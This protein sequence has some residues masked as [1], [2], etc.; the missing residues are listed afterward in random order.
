MAPLPESKE[1]KKVQTKLYPFLVRQQQTS[2]SHHNGNVKNKDDKPKSTKH[3]Q[4]KTTRFKEISIS[5]QTFDSLDKF[6]EDYEE[7]DD[8]DD[9]DIPLSMLTV[10]PKARNSNLV[11]TDKQILLPSN[12][13]HEMMKKRKR[14]GVEKATIANKIILV[15][16][17]V[18]SDHLKR[19]NVGVPSPLGQADAVH[20]MSSYNTKF[21]NDD[22]GTVM[23]ADDGEWHGD[24]DAEN[25]GDHNVTARVSLSP[26]TKTSTLPKLD[27]RICSDSAMDFVMN[28]DSG[29]R[30]GN[31]I[32]KRLFDRSTHGC[33]LHKTA[34]FG[35]MANQIYSRKRTFSR[36]TSKGA[37]NECPDWILSSKWKIPSWVSL[38]QPIKYS[39]KNTSVDHMVWDDMGV[40]LAVAC[41]V[42]ISIYDW[43]MVR[44]ADLQGRRDRS[45]KCRDSGWKIEPI[46]QFRA[47]SPVSKLVWN[48]FHPDELVVCLR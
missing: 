42:T 26:H 1:T 41:D 19:G 44:A 2:S 14:S 30:R 48:H 35:G 34:G 8:D 4:R 40:L 46:L 32:L 39:S 11:R 38:A 24:R 21:S 28:G 5:R 45:R 17:V 31:N 29:G 43:D 16:D 20:K 9:D 10:R 7:Y 23:N 6:E 25:D 18:S 36:P 12:R 27:T 13:S 37:S 3:P 15:E 47:P 22:S 33:L